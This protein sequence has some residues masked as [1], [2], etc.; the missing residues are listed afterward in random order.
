MVTNELM[1]TSRFQF[2]ADYF[3]YVAEAGLSSARPLVSA[4][5]AALQV[6]V[7]TFEFVNDA[8]QARNYLISTLQSSYEKIYSEAYSLGYMRQSFLALS[9]HIRQW[10][11]KNVN[12]YLEDNGIKVFTA[13]ASIMTALGDAISEQNVE[14]A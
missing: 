8:F 5:Q 7:S 3:A 12:S 10:T 11:G 4:V 6:D 1:S 13:Y 2:Y 9:D 14:E